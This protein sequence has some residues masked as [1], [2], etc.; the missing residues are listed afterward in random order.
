[1]NPTLESYQLT[2]WQK[3]LIQEYSK[4]AN[5]P[6]AKP[7]IICVVLPLLISVISYQLSVIS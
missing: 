5:L 3:T 1:T 7:S 6:D 4:L 2:L